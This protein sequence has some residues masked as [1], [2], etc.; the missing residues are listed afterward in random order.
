MEGGMRDATLRSA[1]AT[2]RAFFAGQDD[3]YLTRVADE[4]RAGVFCFMESCHC[5]RGL[6]EGGYAGSHANLEAMAGEEALCKIGYAA[7]GG[8]REIEMDRREK[9]RRSRTLPLV[10]AEIRRRTKQ[11]QPAPEAERVC[12]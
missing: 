7:N 1:K 2:L 12:L 4:C 9:L 10:L 3:K 8:I 5:L 11:S 6:L